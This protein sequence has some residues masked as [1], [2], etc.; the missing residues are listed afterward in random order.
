MIGIASVA[1]DALLEARRRSACLE[2]TH[3]ARAAFETIVRDLAKEGV[4]PGDRRQVK[5][6]GVVRAFAFL[7]GA[8]RV[9]PEHLEIARFCLWDDPIEQ[10][11]IVARLIAKIANPPGMRI[12]QMLVE[13]DEILIDAN[14]RDLAK[15]ATA[16]AKLGEVERR[17]ADFGSDP[18]GIK[19]R[20]YV[21]DQIRQLRLASL[22]A[23]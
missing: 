4:Q 22:A 9:L 8:E 20:S 14:P 16:A 23:V 7:Q 3:D 1:V 12:N 21:R 15:A 17:L 5:T 11:E 2:W 10:P 19:V 6:V 13:V 18:R